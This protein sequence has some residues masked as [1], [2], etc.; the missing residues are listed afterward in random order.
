MSFLSPAEKELAI[1]CRSSR[2]IGACCMNCVEGAERALG[3]TS[4]TASFTRRSDP[5]VPVE[6]PKKTTDVLIAADGINSTARRLLYPNEGPLDF[7]GRL[8]WRGVSK[9]SPF[10]TGRSMVWAG[11][12]DQKFIAYPVGREAELEGTSLVNWIA[13][14][15]V[16][17]KDDPDLTPPQ[18]DWGKVVPKER[19]ASQFQSWTFGFLSIPELIEETKEVTE[20]PMCDRTPVDRWSF[21]RLTLLGDAAHPLYP[22]GSNGAS[23][24][25]LD[26]VGLS[27]ALQNQTDIPTALRAY[28]RVRLPPTAKICFANRAN[29]PDHVLQLAHERAPDGFENID[30]VIDSIELEEVGRAYKLLAGFDIGSVNKKARETEGLWSSKG[31]ANSAKDKKH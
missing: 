8:L 12:A 24:A 26:A 11:H 5:N 31:K 2:F 13:E 6:V 30:D 1:W 10:L 7:S 19:F 23:Q 27:S 18:A 22:I 20:F 17:D 21:G 25:I 14:L 4:I 3:E 16:Q 15:R 9:R 29:G 28:E